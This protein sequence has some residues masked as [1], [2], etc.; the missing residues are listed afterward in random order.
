LIRDSAGNLYGTASE[1]GNLACNGGAG[2]GVVFAVNSAG[3]ETVL[4]RFKGGSD[5]AFPVASLVRDT[6]GN[7][8]GTTPTGGDIKCN[9]PF[10]CGIAFKVTPGGIKTVLHRFHGIGGDGSFP[11]AG[12]ILDAAG[13][14]YGT[15]SEG[16]AHGAGTVLKISPTRIETV[17]YSFTSDGADGQFPMASL[18][19]DA[20]GN[21]YG[22]TA[23]GGAGYGTVF[24][25]EVNGQETVLHTFQWATDGSYPVAPLIR[26][27]AGNLI[28]TTSNNGP[29]TCNQYGCGTVFKLP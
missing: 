15:T 9:A 22:T 25:V 7:L 5:G 11:E 23:Y 28:G 20:A 3:Q 26:D 1:G 12:L 18:S 8:Y 14:L 19:R 4:Y 29:S 24:K 10:G 17:L 13:N 6:A 2:C 16:G 27:K 21:L